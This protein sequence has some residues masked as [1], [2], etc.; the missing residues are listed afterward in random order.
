MQSDQKRKKN[1]PQAN[2]ERSNRKIYQPGNGASF[3]GVGPHVGN[4]EKEV[5]IPKVTNP[6][7]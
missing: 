1:V 4:D 6:F 3:H 5:D 2:Q 7:Y